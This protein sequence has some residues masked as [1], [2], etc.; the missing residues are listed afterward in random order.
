[1]YESYYG[2]F[3]RPFPAAPDAARYCGV[4]A[5]EQARQTI[6]RCIERAEGPAL[7]VGPS[8]VGKSLLLN[9]LAEQYRGRFLIAALNSSGLCT[10]RALLQNILFELKLPY[11]DLD[12]G[13][14]RL[15]LIDRL[16]PR[17]SGEGL[18]LLIDE[19]HTLPLRLL[20]EVR[21]ITN[22][23]RDGQPRVRLVLAAGPAMEE[24]LANPK[25]DSFQQRIAARCYL[26]PLNR[27]ECDRYVDS[28][29]T[30]AGGASGRA[31]APE[32]LRAIFAATDG[33]PR[34]VNQLCDH[35]LLLGATQGLP[36]LTAATIEAAWSDLQQLPL[37]W[38]PEAKSR[39]FPK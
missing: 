32:A 13:E 22:L 1:M 11:R 28:Q 30:A 24:R 25:L 37:P 10:R 29:W 3:R 34:L 17:N 38:A 8:G 33:V 31:F 39:M 35:A 4:G 14:L 21:L 7:L 23:V 27:G 18:L 12:E 26:H 20:E 36:T 16:E 9:V 2:L 15:S 6:A 19:A 5:S